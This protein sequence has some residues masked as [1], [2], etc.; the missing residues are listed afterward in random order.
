M[1]RYVICSIVCL[2]QLAVM[3]ANAKA[4]ALPVA[5]GF[6]VWEGVTEGGHIYGRTIVPSDLRQ[7]VTVVVEYESEKIQEHLE[8]AI[9]YTTLA[10]TFRAPAA[11]EGYEP[12][13]K[14][15]VVFSNRGASQ[16][17]SVRKL[18][19]NDKAEVRSRYDKYRSFAVPFYEGLKFQNTPNGAGSRP[20]IYVLGPEG[21][22][23]LASGCALD[24][25][26]K[27]EV[28]KAV[29]KA[30]NALPGRKGLAGVSESKYFPEVFK[31]IAAD[32]PLGV[33]QRQLLA[34]VA[35][36]NAAKARE[37]QLIYDLL[38][39]SRGFIE[40][41]LEAEQKKS[42]IRAAYDR[43]LLKRYW[44]EALARHPVKAKPSPNDA[45]LQV[46][47]EAYV[48]L[49]RYREKDSSAQP[50]SALGRL[51][52]L[53][54]KVSKIAQR[55]SNTKNADHGIVLL[56]NCAMTV[57]RDMDEVLA[58]VPSPKAK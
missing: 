29:A 50:A 11:W 43:D 48:A 10:P 13:N 1:F 58:K 31:A 51:K 16:P 37:A 39:Q 38:E 42:P 12:E 7:R 53:E 9:W 41:R 5:D 3:G 57:E 8:S 15:I 6:P 35:D 14:V 30:R 32:R 45:D 17:D 28:I 18:V 23:V 4:N 54:K 24:E 2:L 52:G 22:E 36:A 26:V 19:E 34:S 56:Q 55:L 47:C 33:V 21:M 20:F 44:P 46:L 40:Y 25:K 49:C 27:K